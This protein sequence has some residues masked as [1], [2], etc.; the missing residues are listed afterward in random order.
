MDLDTGA[1][2]FVGDTK[3]H[4][5]LAVAYYMKEELRTF[6]QQA[7]KIEAK[8]LVNKWVAKA[9]SSGGSQNIRKNFTDE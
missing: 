7:N 5:A 1:V 4:E 2:I 6:W 9:V 3:G 8:K